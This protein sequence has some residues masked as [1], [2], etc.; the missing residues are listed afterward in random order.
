[1]NCVVCQTVLTASDYCP[2]CG[3]NVKA[4]KK[5]DALSN[6]YYN[7]GL[8]RLKFGIYQEQLPA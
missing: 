2:K 8:E 7:Q 3:C 5:I 1:M 4:L 6:F